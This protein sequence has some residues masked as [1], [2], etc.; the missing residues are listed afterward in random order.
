VDKPRA[1]YLHSNNCNLYLIK[2]VKPHLYLLG[3]FL[4]FRRLN[5]Q[6]TLMQYLSPAT[7]SGETLSAPLDKKAIQLGRKKL[8]AE[9]ELSGGSTIELH[10]K[11]FTKNDIIKYFED[12]LKEDAL[13]YHSAVGQDQ[14]L[15][16]FLEHAW[17]GRKEK[18][19][20]NPLYRDEQFIQWISP[21]FCHSFTA[22]MDGCFQGEPDE[23][24][25][26]SLLNNRLLMTPGD[27]EQSWNAVTRIIMNDISTLERYHEQDKKR[28]AP[29]SVT[30]SEIRDLMEFNY[31]RLIQLL[32][33]GRF[34]SL[35]DQY[36]LCMQ[37]A[38]IDV[39]NLHVSIRSHVKTWLENAK[40]LAVSPEVKNQITKK[41]EEMEAIGVP[42]GGRTGAGEKKGDSSPFK[43]ILFAVIV[44]IKIAT[45]NSWSSR[46][47]SYDYKKT[48]NSI[49][50]RFLDS[51]INSS[52]DTGRLRTEHVAPM[53]TVTVTHKIRRR[54][55][56][57]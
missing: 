28:N 36:A 23:D 1:S 37:N 6:S 50:Q 41:L 17:I 30:V 48:F 7:F 29:G 16:G 25:L 3:I 22:L 26:T 56:H 8:F 31:I 45:C 21:Y 54:S 11:P 13:A 9:L 14:V 5:P 10:G 47:S 44:I 46:S 40:M 33:Q 34:A 15:L 20:D 19:Q 35:R 51:L 53:D 27:L 42:A 32:P 38:C 18:F 24:G 52:R 39:F 2:Y 12:L 57:K 55:G 49:D 43:L 4:I